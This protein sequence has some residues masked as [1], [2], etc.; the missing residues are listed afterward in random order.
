[1]RILAIAI[2]LL[3]GLMFFWGTPRY[4]SHLAATRPHAENAATGQT[5][6]MS[7]KGAD[8]VFI[9]SDDRFWYFT[10]ELSG[11]VMVVAGVLLARRPYR[12]GGA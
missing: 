9:S 8:A 4:V 7:I 11:L 1:M 3:G 12:S 10:L 6:K 5:I 2:F